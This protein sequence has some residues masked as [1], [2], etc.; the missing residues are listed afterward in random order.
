MRGVPPFN[1]TRDSVYNILKTYIKKSRPAWPLSIDVRPQGGEFMTAKILIADA[2]KPSVVMSSEVF[3]DKVP[4]AQVFVADTGRDCL[5]IVKTEK[6]DL[7]L[8]DFDLP[9]SDGASLYTAIRKIYSGP[10]LLSAFT[11]DVTDQAVS[12][13]LF[14][15]NDAGGLIP[16]PVKFDVLSEKIEKFLIDKHRLVKRFETDLDSLL[17]AK[18]AGRGK[19][20]PKVNGRVI[21]ISLGGARIELDGTMKMKKQQEITLSFKIPTPSKTKSKKKTTKTKTTK[22]KTTRRSNR[23]TE[24]KIKA[25]VAWYTKEE[26]GLRFSKL[27]DVQKRGLE[28]FLRDSLVHVEE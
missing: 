4:G 20:A 12:D 7:V 17:I 6:P 27:T 16:K 22:S 25:N 3:K 24:T 15:Y 8:I 1:A 2:S 11:D 13:L 19:R 26:V 18:A 9:D 5:E 28:A 10:V 14:A 21:N 23:G